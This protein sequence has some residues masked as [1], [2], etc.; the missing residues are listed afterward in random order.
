MKRLPDEQQELEQTATTVKDLETEINQELERLTLLGYEESQFLLVKQQV[1]KQQHQVDEVKEEVHKA[2][3][4]IIK[5]QKDRDHI[6]NEL[7]TIQ[8]LR[9]EID[10]LKEEIVNLKLLDYHF[11]IFRQELS[12]RIRPLIAS[13]ASELLHLTTQGRYSVIELDED[14]NVYLYDQTMQFPLARFSGGEQDLV[15][16]CLRIA[17]SQVV[18]E[19]SGRSQINFIVLDEIFGSQD[20]QRKDLILSAL[21]H[22]SSQFRQIFIITHVEGV[23]DALPVIISVEEK[24]IEDSV[25]K[26]L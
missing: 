9:Q 22:L 2:E 19:R 23:K 12:G 21:Q 20:E 13:R 10:R 17:I 1:E 8:K 25:A 4:E 14:Y 3:Q 24:S 16:L 6:T 11:G 26:L 5:L 7:D 15:N 18:S